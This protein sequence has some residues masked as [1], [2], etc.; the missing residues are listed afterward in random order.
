MNIK[1]KNF[2]K[3]GPAYMLRN[4]GEIFDAGKYHP[5][6]NYNI[7]YDDFLL[8]NDGE[9]THWW[10][11]FY[12]HTNNKETKQLIIECIKILYS[13]EMGDDVGMSLP[14]NYEDIYSYFGIKRNDIIK[15]VEFSDFIEKANKLNSLINQ[16]FIRFRVGG[17]MTPKKGSEDEIYFRVGSKGFNW[18]DLIW[19]LLYNNQNIANKV[20]ITK[21][22]QS[23]GTAETL[24]IKGD[25]LLHYPIKDF[26]ELSGRPIIEKLDKLKNKRI[27]LK[28]W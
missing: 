2:L 23:L 18:F 24:K 21:D 17:Y 14:D 13:L 26:I 6:I 15:D 3:I 28:R 9:F 12:E 5:Y 22:E 8:I 10:V 16:E 1:N 19:T 25:L 27:F 7:E 11:W 20:T 4:D